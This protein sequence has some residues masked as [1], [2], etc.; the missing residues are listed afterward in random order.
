MADGVNGKVDGSDP[1][2]RS[3][4]P[5]DY[6]ESSAVSSESPAEADSGNPD[7]PNVQIRDQTLYN[8]TPPT[9]QVLTQEQMQQLTEKMK[10]EEAK[11]YFSLRV[12][13]ITIFCP[14]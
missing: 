14:V 6:T 4:R 13:K 5:P 7:V 1:S 8:Q 3:E 9:S 11:K 10:R 2:I 12:S